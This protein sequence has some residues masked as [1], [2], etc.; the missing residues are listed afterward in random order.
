M[1]PLLEIDRLLPLSAPPCGD[2]PVPFLR[3]VGV[4]PAL[5]MAPRAALRARQSAVT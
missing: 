2:P 3:I 4:L 5:L 1:V